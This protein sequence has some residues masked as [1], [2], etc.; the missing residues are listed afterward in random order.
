MKVLI[1]GN[2]T[3]ENDS[4]PIKLL[5]KLQQK[6]SNI[7]FQEIDPTEGLENYGKD[8]TIIDTVEGIK[9]VIEIN[10]FEQLQTNKLFSMHDFDLAYNLKLLKK[11]GKI[12]S[13]RIIGVPMEISEE[14]ALDQIQ[15]IF[16]KWAA[17]DI[18]GS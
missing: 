3:I 6:F 5:P 12:D 9:E 14:E 11:I 1:F 18:Q 16:K 4:L 7:D 13:V 10:N 15:L 17:Q 2:P 8:L